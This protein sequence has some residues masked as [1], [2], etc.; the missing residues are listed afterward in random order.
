MQNENLSSISSLND[1]FISRRRWGEGN[2]RALNSRENCRCSL[3]NSEQVE[4]NERLPKWRSLYSALLVTSGQERAHS[5]RVW[6]N[7]DLP[8][9]VTPTAYCSIYIDALVVPQAM[10]AR[11][12]V[13]PWWVQHASQVVQGDGGWHAAFRRITTKV[14]RVYDHLGCV[15]GEGLIGMRGVAAVHRRL[16]VSPDVRA[17]WRCGH[18]LP[19]LHVHGLNTRTTCYIAYAQPV[20]QHQKLL[21]Q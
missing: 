3:I 19:I 8:T 4:C 21:G 9:L 11:R 14:A 5:P 12:V 18:H 13:S 7:A 20:S 17:D 10:H 2:H 15:C 6:G 1:R 16:L